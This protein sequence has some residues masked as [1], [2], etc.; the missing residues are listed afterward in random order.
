MVP[1]Q[2]WETLSICKP[3]NFW[4]IQQISPC[5]P[6]VMCS[7][8][9]DAPTALLAAISLCCMPLKMHASASN[10]IGNKLK[11]QTLCSSECCQIISE[12]ADQSIYI[13]AVIL[14]AQTAQDCSVQ[15]TALYIV[16][17]W[18]VIE[19]LQAHYGCTR[20]LSVWMLPHHLC[21][22]KW[23]SASMYQICEAW[24][25]DCARLQHSQQISEPET[26]NH[27]SPHLNTICH[28]A[29]CMILNAAWRPFLRCCTCSDSAVWFCAF[30]CCCRCFT[31]HTS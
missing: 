6:M 31:R 26:S 9:C 17:C 3:S 8:I 16:P 22:F 21:H 14:K 15:N 7:V 4:A 13:R 30:D 24:I 18:L 19:S 1:R 11:C 20:P 28:K 10:S 27:A 25:S 2:S 5:T 12:A 23:C 29:A